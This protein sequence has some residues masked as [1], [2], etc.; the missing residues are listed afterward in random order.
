MIEKAHVYLSFT[1]LRQNVKIRVFSAY[2][3]ILENQISQDL[4]VAV[5]WNFAKIFI[6]LH[7]FK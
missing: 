5:M 6:F 1:K 3:K 4:K 2:A 7:I